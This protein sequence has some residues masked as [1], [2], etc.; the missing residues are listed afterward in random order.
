MIG[1]SMNTSAWP[2]RLGLVLALLHPTPS[3]GEE[4]TVGDLDKALEQIR[5]E[6]GAVIQ[7]IIRDHVP[8]LASCVFSKEWFNRA[9]DM[10]L[11]RQYLGSNLL[12]DVVAPHTATRPSDFIDPTGKMPDHFCSDTEANA[13]WKQRL[14]AFQS[15]DGPVVVEGNSQSTISQ[16]RVDV[17]MPV[18]DAKFETAVVVVSVL[19]QAASKLKRS[20]P[21][22]AGCSFVYQKR[23]GGW[24]QIHQ[25][26]DYT[27]N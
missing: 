9:V 2:I 26:M 27:V 15:S 25:T 22:G 12:A 16:L 19:R 21:E 5:Q 18:F 1:A 14:A 11:A 3:P 24:V 6:T 23:A 10:T 17:A 20:I 8:D 7:T 4:G 13:S